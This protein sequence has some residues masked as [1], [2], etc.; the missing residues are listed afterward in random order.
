MAAPLSAWLAEVPVASLK[1]LRLFKGVETHLLEA[2]IARSATRS[3]VAGECLLS[4]AV[5][6]QYMYLVLEGRLR[7][8]LGSPENPPIYL[9]GPGECSG[10]ISFMD[11]ER[12]SAHVIAEADTLVLCLHRDLVLE[13]IERSSKAMH[14]LLGI[15]CER[16]RRG[17]QLIVDTERN[18]NVDT[19]TGLFNR[20]RLEQLFERESTRCA[21][22][23][24]PLSLL[25]LDVD[26][27]KRY[28][29]THGH[30][31]GDYALCLVANTLRDQLRPK[32]SMARYGGE[33]FVILLPEIDRDEAIAIAERLRQ[34]LAEIK[35]FYSPCGRL[36][37]VTV[38]IGLAQMRRADSLDELVGRADKS[39]YQAKDAGRNRISG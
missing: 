10:E 39:L 23:R 9:L 21:F 12:P 13:L 11:S 15:L 8:H 37:G 5:I 18:A 7:V 19:L 36:P 29:D 20:R 2:L 1:D 30:L 24:Q 34:S 38:S 25:M 35:D 6:N 3:L 27:F 16:M 32:D 14:N 4:P 26:H 33:E 31:A 22:N 28:N 17:N